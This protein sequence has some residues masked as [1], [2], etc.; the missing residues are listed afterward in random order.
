MSTEGRVASLKAKH[1]LLDKKISDLTAG[2]AFSDL[3]LMDLKKEKLAVKD[4]L[5]QIEKAQEAA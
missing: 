5:A 2:P 3:E 4:E 1:T